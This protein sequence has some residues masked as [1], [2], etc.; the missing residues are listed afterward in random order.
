MI[1]VIINGI[2]MEVVGVRKNKLLCEYIG[3]SPFGLGE[4]LRKPA[5]KI[6]KSRKGYFVESGRRVYINEQLKQLLGQWFKEEANGNN[7]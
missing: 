7:N 3:Q 6:H 1:K 5:F 4:V 2:E